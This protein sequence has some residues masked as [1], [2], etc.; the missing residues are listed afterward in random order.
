MTIE[1]DFV[2]HKLFFSSGAGGSLSISGGPLGP[3]LAALSSL[4]LHGM[5]DLWDSASTS[6]PFAEGYQYYKSLCSWEEHPS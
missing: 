1:A 6:E 2:L 3:H 4:S 5:Q